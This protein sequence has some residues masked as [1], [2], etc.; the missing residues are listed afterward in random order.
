MRFGLGRCVNTTVPGA[1]V[2]VAAGGGVLEAGVDAGAVAGGDNVAGLLVA[3]GGVGLL[4]D[5][6]TGPP[7]FEAKLVVGAGT[8]SEAADLALTLAFAVTFAGLFAIRRCGR[9]ALRWRGA[10]VLRL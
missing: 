10:I 2:G 6:E 5:S 9:W 7:E 8:G 3:P 4:A 1:R